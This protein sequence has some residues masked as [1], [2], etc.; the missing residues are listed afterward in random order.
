MPNLVENP[1]ELASAIILSLHAIIKPTVRKT[2][3]MQPDS[4][5]DKTVNSMWYSGLGS[6]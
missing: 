1:T 4:A 3:T 5:Q 2:D 6:E